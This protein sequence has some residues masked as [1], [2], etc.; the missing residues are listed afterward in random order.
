MTNEEELE[1][2]FRSVGDNLPNGIVYQFRRNADGSH[3]F[4]YVSAGIE[5]TLGLKPH[6]V[7][8]DVDLVFGLM[9]PQTLEDYFAAEE[10]CVRDL[11]PYAGLLDFELANGRC[12]WLQVQ[13]RPHRKSDGAVVWDGLAIDVT[14]R[15]LGEQKAERLRCL[16]NAVTDTRE[17]ISHASSEVALFDAVCRILSESEIVDTA[18]VSVHAPDGASLRP[19]AAHG[20][21]ASR[22]EALVVS[23]VSEAEVGH[24]PVTRAWRERKPASL[25]APSLLEGRWGDLASLFEWTCVGS[26]PISCHSGSR[27]VLTL[28]GR[29]CWFLDGEAK[30]L[31]ESLL[32]DLTLALDSLQARQALTESQART[33]ALLGVIP[34]LILTFD[35]DGTYLASHP[36]DPSQYAVPPEVFMHRRVDEV[37]PEPAAGALLGAIRAAVASRS[38]QTTRYT[39]LKGGVERWFEARVKPFSE[40]LVVAVV[41]DVTESELSRRNLEAHHHHLEGVVRDRT[42]ALQV[43]LESVRRSEQRFGYAMEAT[44][45]GLWDWDVRS[46]RAYLSPAW[47]EMLGYPPAPPEKEGHA[48]PEVEVFSLLHPD[49]HDRVLHATRTHLL[50]GS[51]FLDVE[52]RLRNAD[53]TYKWVRSRA[54]VVERDVD[55]A[56]LRVVGTHIDLSL[57]KE[58][59]LE[60]LAKERAEAA[61][62]AKSAFLANVSHEIRTP[63]NAITGYAHL[64]KEVLT[65]PAQRDHL[66][67]LTASSLHLQRI[68]ND[69]LDLT[70]IEADHFTLERVNVDIR[71]L[72]QETRTMLAE[73]IEARGLS[74]TI[75]ID[76]GL[77]TPALLGD[78]FRLRQILANYLANA[79]RFT[80][81]GCVQVRA[82]LAAQGEGH[83]TIRFEVEDSGIGLTEQQQAQLFEPFVQAEASTTRRFGGTGLGLA[84]SRKLA[85]LM[86]GDTGVVSSVGHGS[87]F[88]FTARLERGLVAVTA[89]P[90]APHATRLRPGARILLVEDNPLNQELMRLTL[91]RQGAV[92][93][94]AVHG[95]EALRLFAHNDYDLILMDLQMPELDGYAATRD[96]RALERG[97]TVPIVA[98]TASAMVEER[99]RCADVGMNDCLVKPIRPSELCAALVRWIPEADRC[100]QDDAC[101]AEGAAVETAMSGGAADVQASS[102]PSLINVAEGLAHFDGDRETYDCM[103]ARF[104]EEA[105]LRVVQLREALALGTQ[106]L[107]VRL[108][109]TLKSEAAVLGLDGVREQAAQ[110]EHALVTMPSGI[111]AM[112]GV[113]PLAHVVEAV[114][115]ALEE[116]RVGQGRSSRT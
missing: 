96:I 55:G 15:V 36:A 60:L 85:R 87:T 100:G 59:E 61:N 9:P 93:E 86:G 25:T 114:R 72:V 28:C 80:P 102:G 45:D 88:W 69:L 67:K 19:V 108:A 116:S 26:F 63:L 75:D 70:K 17:A 27:G 12:C 79:V 50:A 23:Q 82:Q 53:G 77:N 64:L 106:P 35:R 52:L 30:P 62:R 92:V 5:A 10:V 8:A 43:A 38:L 76:E 91:E 41:R 68:V 111:T 99:K 113:E 46:N 97:R 65:D 24:C 3:C 107:A 109:H 95:G 105:P 39:L 37:L 21:G 89:A 104:V 14:D 90:A 16:Q 33:Q 22:R 84:I 32:A 103:L 11:T 94:L 73:A 48:N 66:D 47:Y 4:T 40:N 51:G 57:R 83:A 112:P 6:E 115:A 20:S 34:D 71:A 31:L 101:D 29:E 54:K 7:L 81:S 56:P 58:M 49:D 98:V 110:V 44:N 78:P 18:F 74:V 42:E 1:Q 13:S 2:Q